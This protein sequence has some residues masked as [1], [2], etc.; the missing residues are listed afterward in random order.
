M[1]L[2]KLTLSIGLLAA[3]LTVIKNVDHRL[4]FQLIFLK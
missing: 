1:T 4:F 2:R 3:S